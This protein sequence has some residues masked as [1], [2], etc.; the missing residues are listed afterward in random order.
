MYDGRR[1]KYDVDLEWVNKTNDFL[2][3]AFGNAPAYVCITET[4]VLY[5]VGRARK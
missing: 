3:A 2:D 4:L 5:V 1:N